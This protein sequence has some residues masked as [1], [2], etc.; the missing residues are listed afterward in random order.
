[1]PAKTNTDL[2]R[3]L[4]IAVAGIE[5]REAALRRDITRLEA[6]YGETTKLGTTLETRIKVLEEKLVELKKASEENARKRWMLTMAVVG[7][8]L[9]LVANLVLSLIRR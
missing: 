4:M 3:E 6:A 9:T 7:A 5:E 2:I 8:I 1:M